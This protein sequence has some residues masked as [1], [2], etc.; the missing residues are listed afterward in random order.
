M[1]LIFRSVWSDTPDLSP[2]FGRQHFQKWVR[3]RGFQLEIAENGES[4]ETRLG[5]TGR[6]VHRSASS[7]GE[8]V[9]EF[10][11]HEEQ[12]LTQSIVM[13]RLIVVAT[14]ERES[15]FSIDVEKQGHRVA[16]YQDFRPPSLVKNMINGGTAP[17]VDGFAYQS[18]P[19]VMS[20]PELLNLASSPRRRFPLLIFSDD[21]WDTRQ[22]LPERETIAADRL[23]GAVQIIHADVGQTRALHSSGLSDQPFLDGDVLLVMPTDDSWR[24]SNSVRVLS[25]P[26]IDSRFTPVDHFLPIISSIATSRRLPEGILSGIK[27]LRARLGSGGLDLLALAEEIIADHE[28]SLS[29]LRERIATLE[30]DLF[31]TQVELE[32]EAAESNFRREQF[33]YLFASYQGI[34]VNESHL[35]SECRTSS[36]V[37][38]RARTTLSSLSIPLGVEHDLSDVDSHPLRK[39]W[40]TNLWQGLRAL[41]EYAITN[42]DGDFRQWCLD[43]KSA[44][45]WSGSPKK[46]AMRESESTESNQK[47]RDQRM[48]PVT[49][50]LELS[51]RKLMVAHLKIASTG[52]VLIPRVYFYD[53]TRGSTQKVHI[54]FIGPHK[55]IENTSTN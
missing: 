39:V 19:S 15:L 37:V 5:R 3:S 28:N 50:D 20:T 23:L 52:S 33:A 26:E 17:L 35:D 51:G 40:A 6:L 41:H 55:A 43:G 44:H 8:N 32:S 38:E 11:L 27:L 7:E 10:E 29:E 21:P 46:L 12:S 48:F 22:G 13:T 4:T 36:E 54:G 49:Q 25:R 34:T 47:L 45:T 16:T 2:D 53:D 18:S 24:N 42:F 9:H 14:S 1:T 31:D 30:Q